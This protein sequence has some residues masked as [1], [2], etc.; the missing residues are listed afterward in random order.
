VDQ[1]KV[2]SWT[3]MPASFASMQFESEHSRFGNP[4]RFMTHGNR[5]SAYSDQTVH[6]IDANTRQAEKPAQ[7]KWPGL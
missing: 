5:S 4:S 2:A 7:H 3:C 1:A 6:P